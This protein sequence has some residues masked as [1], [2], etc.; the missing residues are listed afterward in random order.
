MCKLF[1]TFSGLHPLGKT[2]IVMIIIVVVVK[3]K[4]GVG[5]NIETD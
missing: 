3:A 2:M 4:K 1:F 5:G